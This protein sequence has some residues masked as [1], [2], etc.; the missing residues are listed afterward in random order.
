LPHFTRGYLAPTRRDDE[1][2]GDTLT[3]VRVAILAARGVE[4]VELVQPRQAVI[5]AGATAE[6]LSIEPGTIQATNHDIEPADEFDVEAR[7]PPRV[8]PRHRHP[9]CRRQSARFLVGR[10]KLVPSPRGQV[11]LR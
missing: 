1:G 4:Q 2:D 3:G 6:L 5:D 7:R 9:L 10:G 8:L 11:G